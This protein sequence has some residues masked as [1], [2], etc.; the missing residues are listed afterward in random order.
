MIIETCGIPNAN[1]PP[2]R[3]E[4][5]PQGM[6]EA[7]R[8]IPPAI[9]TEIASRRSEAAIIFELSFRVITERIASGVAM[10]VYLCASRESINVLRGRRSLDSTNPQQFNNL[11]CGGRST[12][13]QP[14]EPTARLPAVEDRLPIVLDAEAAPE[15]GTAFN[16]QPQ[17]ATHRL[18]DLLRRR[19]K[20]AGTAKVNDDFRGQDSKFLSRTV[21]CSPAT[22]GLTNKSFID[23]RQL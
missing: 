23:S 20:A 6:T 12:A 8:T 5:C 16:R 11:V 7:S 1:P 22:I 3:P 2:G 17:L 4:N 13:A 15:A 10:A 14:S 19:T 18:G 21:C 9:D